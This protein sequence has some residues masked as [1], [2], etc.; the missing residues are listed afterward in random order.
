VS[1]SL[2]NSGPVMDIPPSVRIPQSLAILVAVFTSEKG[3]EV[4]L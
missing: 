3:K 1:E 4:K 2:R